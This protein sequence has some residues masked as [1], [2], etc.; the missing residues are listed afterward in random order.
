[1]G[2]VLCSARRFSARAFMNLSISG[3]AAGASLGAAGFS[4]AGGGG[5][6]GALSACCAIADD[7]TK[8]NAKANKVRTGAF[9]FSEVGNTTLRRVEGSM[10]SVQ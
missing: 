5:G 1:M 6:G 7:A 2:R 9:R 10:V 4:S 8:I 3:A